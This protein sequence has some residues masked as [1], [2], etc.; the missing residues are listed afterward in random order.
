MEGNEG[1]GAVGNSQR[2]RQRETMG[3]KRRSGGAVHVLGV[4]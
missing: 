3:D 2:T 1:A 4:I